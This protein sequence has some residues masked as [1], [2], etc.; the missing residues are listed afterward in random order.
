VAETIAQVD[1][2]RRAEA[3]VGRAYDEIAARRAQAKMEEMEEKKKAAEDRC[4]EAV[5]KLQ[6]A[7]DRA[8]EVRELL[9]YCWERC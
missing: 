7:L 9:E 2:M 4:K 8:A 5:E 1:L 3:S 6:D